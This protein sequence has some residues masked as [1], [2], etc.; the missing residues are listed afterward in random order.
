MRER[1]RC[2]DPSAN[3]TSMYDHRVHIYTN[4]KALLEIQ[5]NGYYFQ[6]TRTDTVIKNPGWWKGFCS[7]GA[8]IKGVGAEEKTEIITNPSLR[9]T[10]CAV[11]TSTR[12]EFLLIKVEGDQLSRWLSTNIRG[13]RQFNGLCTY[14]SYFLYP[15]QT[16]KQE[17]VLNQPWNL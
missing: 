4:S 8:R 13:N 5:M 17:R 7:R 11:M 14:H 12:R 10:A 1:D 9:S 16:D 15:A 2:I 6:D 3:Q